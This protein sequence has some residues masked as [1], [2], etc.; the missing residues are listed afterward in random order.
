MSP[1]LDTAIR[2]LCF[3][4]HDGLVMQAVLI[5]WIEQIMCCDR[6]A[7]QQERLKLECGTFLRWL[8]L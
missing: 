1:L 2:Q 3:G 4:Q 5:I 7:T 6:C 8:Q